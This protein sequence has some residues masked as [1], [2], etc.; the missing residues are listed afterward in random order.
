MTR[1]ELQTFVNSADQ[2]FLFMELGLTSVW[3]LWKKWNLLM[4][5][6]QLKFQSFLVHIN[7]FGLLKA[8]GSVIFVKSFRVA[9]PYP[10][11]KVDTSVIRKQLKESETMWETKK[12]D[13]QG[14]KAQA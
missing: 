6:S 9:G 11:I 14:R 12:A 5:K 7:F 3:P 1:I 8:T 2:N 4:K 10:R 13:I